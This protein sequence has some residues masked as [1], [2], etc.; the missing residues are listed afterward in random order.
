M[1]QASTETTEKARRLC[2]TTDDQ[3]LLEWLRG[4]G[5]HEVSNGWL[6]GPKGHEP[7]ESELAAINY[8]VE[9]WDYGGLDH[10]V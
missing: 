9:E 7:T 2:G 3:A 10:G 8:L 4:R 6:R 5:I 1:P